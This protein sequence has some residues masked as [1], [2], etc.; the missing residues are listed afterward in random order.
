MVEILLV[1]LGLA[2]FLFLFFKLLLWYATQV[3]KITVERR[4][5]DADF[6]LATGRAPPAWA[7][8]DAS[9][10]RRRALRR[11]DSLIG[12]MKRTSLVDSD[13]TRETVLA[14]LVETRRRWEAAP[15]S[16]VG[17]ET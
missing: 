10:A 13:E 3:T 17:P 5:R 1:V 9:R 4:H 7:A 16:E 2:A 6:I 11:L 15:W 12:Y 14:Q 8:G